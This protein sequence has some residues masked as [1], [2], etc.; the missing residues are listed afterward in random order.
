MKIGRYISFI[1]GAIAGLILYELVS[2]WRKNGKAK[3]NTNENRQANKDGK[4]N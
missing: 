2:R 1:A 3:Q 4:H